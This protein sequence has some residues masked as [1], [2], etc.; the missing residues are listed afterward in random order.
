[1]LRKITALFMLGAFLLLPLEAEAT[2]WTKV[3]YNGGAVQT[4]VDPKDWNNAFTV[5]ADSITF[6][7]NDG[8][9]VRIAPRRVTTLTYGQEAHRHVALMA[10]LG[11]L[12]TP[13]ALF[14]LFHKQ[15][16]HFIGIEYAGPD[17]TR[18]G[19]LLQG[20]NDNYRQILFALKAATGKPIQT[21][22]EDAQYVNP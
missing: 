20:A 19:L 14:G 10:S 4:K 12:I 7:L 22:A 2:T 17:S 9:S 21:S 18:G 16:L 1:M 8:Q 13:L 6:T 5:T 11:I 3:R 15:R